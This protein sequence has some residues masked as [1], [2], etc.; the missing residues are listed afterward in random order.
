MRSHSLPGSAQGVS[1]MGSVG[2]E[3]REL[4]DRVRAYALP[5]PHPGARGVRLRQR[6]AIKMD[7]KRGWLPFRAEQTI[8]ALGLGFRWTARAALGHVLPVRALDA[9]EGGRGTFRIRVAGVRVVDASGPTV[10]QAEF[11]R[12]LS[13]VP[14]CPVL[15]GSPA[16]AW[17]RDGD[18]LR[19]AADVGTARMRFAMDVD[20]EGRV[21]GGEAM[22]PRDT[23]AGAVP[24]PWRIKVT[25][26]KELG[27]MRIPTRGEATWV[28]PDG[29]FTYIR[30]EVVEA[31]LDEGTA[32]NV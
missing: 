18:R 27:G 32:R 14:W 29:P 10:D 19:V 6:G 26:Y 11:V 22:R 20:G 2:P 23:P 1:Q 12:F 24:T 4:L 30:V 25:D 17:D 31:S 15:F 13:E 7:A 5:A 21:L 28:L 16:L 3:V 9:F 8:D